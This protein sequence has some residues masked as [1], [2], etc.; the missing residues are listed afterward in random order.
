[1]TQNAKKAPLKLL[2]YCPSRP[3]LVDADY[4]KSV[5]DSDFTFVSG[6]TC[7]DRQLKP[8]EDVF[9]DELFVKVPSFQENPCPKI[10]FTAKTLFHQVRGLL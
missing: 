4:K 5:C 6:K 7:R 8:V 10:V 3:I 9:L 2:L 1:M